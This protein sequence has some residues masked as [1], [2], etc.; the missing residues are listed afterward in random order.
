MNK[1]FSYD[2]TNSRIDALLFSQ[3]EVVDIKTLINRIADKDVF[4]FLIIGLD[5]PLDRPN[6][7]DYVLGRNDL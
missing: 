5:A 6:A 2:K 1:I 7:N 4:S 3:F